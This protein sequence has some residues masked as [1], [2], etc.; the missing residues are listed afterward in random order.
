MSAL[1]AILAHNEE[2]R[3][4]ACIA[5][6]LAE[7]N[8]FPIH[9]VVNGSHDRTA[10]IAR[11]FGPRVTVHDFAAGGKSRSWNQ[12][13]FDVLDG[14]AEIH[15]FVDGDAEIAPGSIATLQAELMANPDANAASGMPL[16]GRR[17]A[18]YQSKMREE[19]GLFGDLYAIRGEFL[20]QMKAANIRLPV[21][22][23]G[24]DGLLGSLAKTN[25]MSEMNWQN[26]RVVVCPA[27]GFYCEPAS[28]ASVAT[29]KMQYTRQIN[30]SL[31]HFQNQIIKD[32][33]K[34]QGPNALPIK[35]ATY[36]PRYL[37]IF[38]PRRGLSQ[39]WFD[40]RA[41]RRMQAAAANL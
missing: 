19:N 30:Y 29:W 18:F 10:Q 21:D 4:G 14:F 28:F 27:A 31:R 38:S 17:A 7:P 20:A 9:V 25:L 26:N 32:I 22:L 11:S 1:V 37:Q 23:V 5:S 2:A 33:M 8:D 35:L 16:N 13:V 40:R 41:L 15:I 6:L 12:F 34:A 3:I 39:Y 36:Y 24:D